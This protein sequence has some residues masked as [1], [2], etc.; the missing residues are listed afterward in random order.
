MNGNIVVIFYDVWIIIQNN[1]HSQLGQYS[2][3][4]DT[5]AIQYILYHSF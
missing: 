4:M 5:L 3:C 2:G 1:I